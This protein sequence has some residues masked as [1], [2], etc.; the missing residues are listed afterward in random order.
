[1]QTNSGYMCEMRTN[2][3]C[4]WGVGAMNISGLCGK[5]CERYNV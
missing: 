5:V 1:M 2:L 3:K 4:H